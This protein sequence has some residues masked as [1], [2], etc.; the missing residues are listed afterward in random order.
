MMRWVEAAM[1]V[2]PVGFR[3]VQQNVMWEM[4]GAEVS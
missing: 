2:D 1:S 3:V 4:H